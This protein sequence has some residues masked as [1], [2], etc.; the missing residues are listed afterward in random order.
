MSQLITLV[1]QIVP[2]DNRRG[3]LY[4]QFM[5]ADVLDALPII[6]ARDFKNAR[7]AQRVADNFILNMTGKSKKV[8]NAKK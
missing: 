6:T 2:N 5:A 7:I 8:R 1:L 4:G 3:P